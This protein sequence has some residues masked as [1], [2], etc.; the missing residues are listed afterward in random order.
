MLYVELMLILQ[1]YTPS[2]PLSGG[3]GGSG[4]EAPCVNERPLVPFM[5]HCFLY[6][7]SN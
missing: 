2:W 7:Q 6:V 4:F 1:L 3:G 5:K